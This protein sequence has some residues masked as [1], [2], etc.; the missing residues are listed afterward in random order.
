VKH[1]PLR[2]ERKK[3]R[4]LGGRRGEAD[5]KRKNEISKVN[6]HVDL[7]AEENKKKK[8][9]KENE[10][11][12]GIFKTVSC[13]RRVIHGK[14]DDRR[15]GE[16]EAKKRNSPTTE[17]Q[18]KGSGQK[19]VSVKKMKKNGCREH[20]LPQGKK[21]EENRCLAEKKRALTSLCM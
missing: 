17:H 21:G 19:G 12:E 3:N 11:E 20:N 5:R 13:G 15:W 10:Y 1:R 7:E 4:T 9:L 18:T 2:I 8:P 16:K 14:Q 6:T